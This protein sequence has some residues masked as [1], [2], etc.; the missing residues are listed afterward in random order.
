MSGFDGFRTGAVAGDCSAWSPNYRN[1]TPSD[2]PAF[3]PLGNNRSRS[4][5][6]RHSQCPKSEIAAAM[7]DVQN[8]DNVIFCDTVDDDVVV[9]RKAP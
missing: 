6:I 4:W 3:I 1:Y 9:R 2:S 5:P 8:Q 7:Y